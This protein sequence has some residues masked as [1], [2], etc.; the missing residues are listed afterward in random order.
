MSPRAVFI[1]GAH[2]DVGKTHVACALIR[3]AREAGLTT[4]AVKPVASGYDP[5]MAEASDPGRL[6]AALGRPVTEA[7]IAQMTPWRFAAALAPP[8]AA[9]AQ[10]EE[11]PFAPIVDFCRDSLA[12]A[13]ADLILVEGVGGLMSPLADHATGLDLVMALRLPVLLVG[14]TYLGA[15]SH[16]LT[17]YEVM[18]AR[19]LDVAAIVV[20]QDAAPLAPDFADTLDLLAAHAASTPVLPAPRGADT[21]WARAVLDRLA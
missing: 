15:I 6:L 7:A 2:T 13:A 4:Q 14:G 3:A 5:A 8:S 10:G 11:L 1:A 16:T 21:N 18:R 12:G 17:A 19:E 20:S 9:R